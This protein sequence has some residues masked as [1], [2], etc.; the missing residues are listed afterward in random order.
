MSIPN[1]ISFVNM[2]FEFSMGTRTTLSPMFES[3]LSV[4]ELC[5]HV[6]VVF[7]MEF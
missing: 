2:M 4:D 1:L 6:L 5:M 7:V 3:K